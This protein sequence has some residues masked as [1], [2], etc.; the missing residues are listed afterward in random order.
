MM[1]VLSYIALFFLF[2]GG[3]TMSTAQAIPYATQPTHEALTKNQDW[4]NTSRPITAQDLSGRLILLDFWTYCCINCIHVI[5]KLQQLEQ[6]FGDKLTVIGVHSAKFTNE[7][8]R[9]NISKAIIRYGIHHPVVN[10][11]D[12]RI[13]RSFKVQ[14]WPT[15]Y[16]ISPTGELIKQFYGEGDLEEMRSTIKDSIETFNNTINTS[17]LPIDLEENKAL[18]TVLKFPSKLTL[19]TNVNNAPALFITDSGHNRIVGTR[20]NGEIFMTIGNG[21]AGFE[22]GTFDT[23]RFNQP[24]G[25][26]YKDGRL[27]IADTVNHAIRVADFKTKTVTTL[28]GTGHRGG[29]ILK[30][31]GKEGKDTALASPWDITFYPDDKTLMIANAGTHQLVSL[32]VE[33]GKIKPYA[34]N[35]R[36]S[37]D[38]GI[39]P[40]NSLSQPSGLSVYNDD[41]YFVDSETSS[42]RVADGVY[43]DTLIGTGLFDF[44]LV[45]G[46]QGTARMQ[47]PLGLSAIDKGVYIADSYNHAVRFYDYKTEKLSTIVK[48]I[49]L[50][51]PNDILLYNE[52]LLVTDTNNHRILSIN[53]KNS[54]VEP[55][56]IHY[57]TT[58]IEWDET[59][60][61]LEKIS[62]TTI[63]PETTV[64]FHYNDGWKLNDDAP[65][66][67][68]IYDAGK[69]PIGLLKTTELK[70]S[71]VSIPSLDINNDYY[72][73]GTLY[74]CEDSPDSP[75]LI[76]SI[77]TKIT[78]DK[79]GTD[80]ID[81]D[82]K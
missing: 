57:P 29:A 62:S 40:I 17:P 64:T 58:L 51:E 56:D 5:P 81:I 18:D 14:A 32:N 33:T 13:W 66:Y 59:L 45:D 76:K 46:K 52:K 1:R 7:G 21:S 30:L 77:E 71:P 37:I 28:A 41:L 49:G 42:L 31:F 4:L 2:A 75:C 63:T 36:E 68:G 24:Q 10:D 20:E 79:N 12:F 26:A 74:Y 3:V 47:H 9:E 44:G 39:F 82:L 34:G 78:I 8:E 35:G 15:L 54:K 25:T 19:E 23:A 22:D 69:Q 48:D 50:N 73:Q 38:D 80:N 11:K 55:F 60:P 72:I 16:L 67:L 70:H 6:E 27:Y 65:S 53:P 43:L 61:N